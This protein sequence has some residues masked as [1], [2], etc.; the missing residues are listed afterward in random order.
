M[1]SQE[2]FIKRLIGLPGET[3]QVVD[4]NVVV[5]NAENPTETITNLKTLKF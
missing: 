3:V 2:F 5:F 4:G 1:V